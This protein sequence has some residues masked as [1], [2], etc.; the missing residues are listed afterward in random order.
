MLNLL[1]ENSS[2][3]IVNPF[4]NYLTQYENKILCERICSV[5]YPKNYTIF[6]IHS[7]KNNIRE[8]SIFAICP[9]DNNSLRKDSIFLMDK[10][11]QDN[12]IVKYKNDIEFKL[13]ENTGEEFLLNINL[14]P[15]L[16]E[17]ENLYIFNSM[18]FSF[19]KKKRY[20]FPSKKE[21][22]K[23]GMLFEYLNEDRWIPKTINNVDL[24]YEKMYKLLMKYQKMR[25]SYS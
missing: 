4:T 19:E 20:F 13:I 10:F 15:N 11:S 3:I 5:L 24:E 9:D 22:I 21:D 17:N 6:P 16:N 7:F 18:S 25:V 14:Y 23:K 12:I 1:D 2:F 8:N